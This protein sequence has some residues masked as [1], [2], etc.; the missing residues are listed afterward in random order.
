L[1][2]E[3]IIKF[4]ENVK[5]YLKIPKQFVI[6]AERLYEVDQAIAIAH[7]LFKDMDITIADDPLE[8]GSLAVCIKGFD[9][10]VS[11][12]NEMSLFINLISA[13]DNFEI[14]SSGTDSIEFNLMFNHVL[15]T[16]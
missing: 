2:D 10:V 12:K 13:A 3:K 9:I 4:A 16:K 7:E 11:N 8:T 1:S 15:T 14:Y 5:E 6:N